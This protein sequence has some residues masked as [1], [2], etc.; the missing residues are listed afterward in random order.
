MLSTFR[1]ASLNVLHFGH[2]LD[3]RIG[4]AIQELRAIQ[5]D[6]LLL[7]EVPVQDESILERI[8][9]E[10]GWHGDI[11]HNVTDTR[12]DGLVSGTAIISRVPFEDVHELPKV[13]PDEPWE[14]PS[15]AVTIQHLDH[16]IHLI[17][18]HLPWG[19]ENEQGRIAV[20]AAIN[21]H[22]RQIREQEPDTLILWGG[23]FNAVPE[24]LT[25][26]WLSG[27]TIYDGDSTFWVDAFDLVGRP[28]SK[29][30]SRTDNEMAWETARS[31]GIS[32]PHLIPGRR[33]DYLKAFG[34]VYGRT[35]H[36]IVFNRWG[37][38][39]AADGLTVSDH[40]GIWADFLLA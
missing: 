7:Q 40:Y 13:L 14:T 17:S 26:R 9:A 39:E 28:E 11:I 21:T 20:A 22:A 30:T 16:R 19:G 8:R 33:I 32:H 5:P 4:L 6:A 34:W 38:S 31:V 10:L 36:P 15:T 37:D 3:D 23:D 35:G 12:H 2:R 27:T 24:S 1:L 29:I 25:N 18:A